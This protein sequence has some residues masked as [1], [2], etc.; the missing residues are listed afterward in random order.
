MSVKKSV[1]MSSNG[2]LFAP[3]SG[4]Q[5]EEYIRYYQL[6]PLAAQLSLGCPGKGVHA[7]QIDR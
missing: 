6:S 3:L 7:Q 4:D 1:N 2:F 5:Q